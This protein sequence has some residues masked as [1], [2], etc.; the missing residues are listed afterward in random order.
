M[1]RMKAEIEENLKGYFDKSYSYNKK[2]YEAQSYSLNVGGKRIRPILMLLTYSLYKN[3]YSSIMAMAMA[4]EM[5]HTYS[6]IHDDLPAMD[7]D[8]LRRGKPTNHKVYGEAMAIL[9]GDA[10]LN[11]AMSLMINYSLKNGENALRAT[12]II[13]ESSGSEGMIGG[14]VVDILNEN[15]K[16]ISE[17][18]LKYMHSKK[19]G[20]LIK[21]SIVAGAI[22]ADRKSTRLNSSH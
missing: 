14:Q 7:N 16:N 5:I 2:I 18:E 15:N 21:A 13:A 8:E 1:N 9:A 10:L 3:N 4:I 22:L 20:E 11:E 19:T 6:L 17:E 12:K